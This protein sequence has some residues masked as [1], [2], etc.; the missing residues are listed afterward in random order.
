MTRLPR[1]IALFFAVYFL[2]GM[3]FYGPVATLYRQ[4]AGLDLFQIG[5]IESISLAAMLLLE[6]PWGWLADRVGLRCTLVA[7]TAL[8]ALSK[9]IFWRA[10]TFG[11]FLAERLVMA[12]AVSGLTGCDA[13]WLFACVG[14]ENSQRAYGVQE[15]CQTAGVLLAAAVSSLLLGENYRLAGLL[16]VVSYG[17]AALLALGLPEAPP[18]P[19]AAGR[20]AG[21][22]GA[23]RQSLELAPFLL[24]AALLE[25]TAQFITVFL[26][27]LQYR[28]AGI[29]T[30]WFGLLYGLVTV[31]ALLG[32]R[33][34]RLTRALG[35]R[36]SGGALFAAS[37]LACLLLALR[38]R[39]A[40]SVGCVAALR[41]CR[42][43]FTPLS[44][45][46]QNRRV[47]GGAAAT[48][49]SCNAMVMDL[50][51]LAMNPVLGAL[52]DRGIEGCLGFCACA[53]LA[54]LGLFQWGYR[55]VARW[56]G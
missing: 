7:S 50:C 21:V 45:T 31:C 23:L 26:N 13:A 16:T 20:P 33:S 6:V 52:A 44:L 15:A 36:R 54:G 18:V 55:N 42:A 29:P 10:E 17:G 35:E 43:L 47:R 19:A 56:D 40:L 11:G 9:V 37:A 46:I 8:F 3:V 24:G 22:G 34:H 39:P 1:G 2:Q 28:R 27:Q 49:L 53:C 25:E 14:E 38:P 5:L 32:A 48:Q 12:G 30:R 4:A 51:A 41:V